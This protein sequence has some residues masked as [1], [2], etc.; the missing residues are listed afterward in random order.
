MDYLS[1]GQ[2]AALLGVS[3]RTVIRY[4]NDGVIKGYKLPGRGNNRVHKSDFVK[5]CEAYELP[6]PQEFATTTAKPSVLVIDDD[7]A[8]CSSICRVLKRHD[9]EPFHAHDGF[10]AGTMLNQHKPQVMTLDIGMPGVNGLD[11]LKFTREHKDFADIK[12]I[13]ISGSANAH[14][15]SAI[16]D[17]ADA[18]IQKPFKNETLIRT[19]VELISEK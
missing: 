14:M 1:T 5:F 19:I 3:P 6:V 13:I 10:Q 16:I 9:F 12:I 2:I 4:L 17:G 18:I 15:Q 11:V 7:I 8:M